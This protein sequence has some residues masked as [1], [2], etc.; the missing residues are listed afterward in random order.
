MVAALVLVAATGRIVAAAP[1]AGASPQAPGDPPPAVGHVPP[2]DAPIVDPFRPP[3]G[4]YGA[5]NRGLEYDTTPG[6]PVRASAPG[7][8]VFAGRIAGSLHVTV[9]HADGVRTSYSFL[10]T[11]DTTLGTAVAAGDVVGTAGDRLHFGAR[12][13][14]AYFDPAMLFTGTAAVELLP[15]EVPPGATPDGEAR[16]LLELAVLDGGPSLGDLA[17]SWR[18]LHQRAGDGLELLAPGVG[19]GGARAFGRGLTLTAALTDRLLFPAPCSD[20][21]PPVRPAGGDDRVAVTVAGLG[22]SS[23]SAAVDDLR[24]GELGYA[25]GRV[26]RFSYGGGR[27]PGTGAGLRGLHNGDGTATSRYT[28]A[29]T[30]GDVGVAARRLADLVEDVAAAEPDATIDV[31]AHSLGGVVARLA[32]L[33]LE[34][35]GFDLGRLGV[36]VTLAA[37]HEGADLAT[38]LATAADAPRA[39]AALDLAAD[40]LDVGLDPDAPVVEQLSERSEAIEELTRAGVPDGVRLLSI[41][42]RGD[43][44]VAAPRTHVDGA[45]EVT[46]PT[47]GLHAHS[48]VVGSDAATAEIARALAGRPPGCEPW[49]DVVA[50]VVVGHAV[51][52]VE[53]D[54]GL[55][56]AAA[57]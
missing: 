30:Q 6:D 28:S 36:V 45:A 4:P 33:D 25:D 39:G 22:S 48:D 19:P 55:V 27:T 15:F 14:D 17:P 38:A 13:G 41:G 56:L 5:G 47:A 50:D 20:E 8:V 12:V 7:V 35:R 3:A 54:L 2:V 1:A 18:W 40:L 43:L 29:D 34:R 51:S 24:T 23:E 16:A 52:A 21:P 32:L 11:V 42:A 46:V 9:R 49:H 26:V 31:Y 44:V 37:P 53:D 10:R 57:G